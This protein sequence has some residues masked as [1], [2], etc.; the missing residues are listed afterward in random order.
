M[1]TIP[2]IVLER[3]LGGRGWSGLE[4]VGALR[5][6]PVRPQRLSKSQKLCLLRLAPDR[7]NQVASAAMSVQ[8]DIRPVVQKYTALPIERL[9]IVSRFED[10]HLTEIRRGVVFVLAAWSGPAVVAFRRFSRVMNELPTIP[11]DLVVLDIDCLT[12]ESA[13]Q[14]FGTD[15]F[16]VGGNGETI[17]VRD[18]GIVA[19]AIAAPDTSEQALRA[20]TRELLDDQVA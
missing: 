7:G 14:L 15:G 5:E 3:K 18:G 19:R 4:R 12:T 9:R 16:P 1:V 10:V 13:T 8:F 6:T 17:W 20:H 2:G 11:L